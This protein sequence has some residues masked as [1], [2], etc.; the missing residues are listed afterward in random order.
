LHPTCI[1]V[2]MTPERGLARTSWIARF[3]SQP[4]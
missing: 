1:T 2:I 3:A 4:H